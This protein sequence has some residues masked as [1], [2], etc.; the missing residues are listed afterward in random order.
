M[1]KASKKEPRVAIALKSS[2][3][4]SKGE[5]PVKVRVT[6]NRVQKFYPVRLDGK[7]VYLSSDTFN[8]IMETKDKDL[9]GD[10]R[11]LKDLF[12]SVESTAATACKTVTSRMVFTFER[13]QKEYLMHE[14]KS[15]ILHLFESYLKELLNDDRIG[16]YDSY[17]NAYHA[18]NKFRG[19]QTKPFARGKEL[20]PEDVTPELLK[21]FD[22]WLNEK[23]CNKT[24]V[25]IYMRA[26]RIIYNN[27]V[28]HNPSLA[29]FYPFARRQNSNRK[30][31]IRTGS[32][33]KGEALSV[34]DLQKFI[35]TTPEEGSPE[36][37]A[38][39]LW[40][41]MFYTSGMNAA[42]VFALQYKDIN[43]DAIRYVRR[44][45]RDTEEQEEVIEIPLSEALKKII[46]AIGN[47]DK[48]PAAYVF[49]VLD[50]SMDSQKMRAVTKQATKT[51][52]KWLSRLCA[53]NKLPEITTYWSRHTAATLLRNSGVPVEMI[54]ELL[55]HSDV[56]VTQEYLKRFS[57]EKKSNAIE[58]AL[59]A[60][61]V[62]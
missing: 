37:R 14:S 39:Q 33:S 2:H 58:A 34:E 54:S 56:R 43:W 27:A 51:I 57:V 6:F 7:P 29:E 45:T 19:G 12:K 46:V 16:S 28:E 55:G 22:K 21:K 48:S 38:K 52:N 13:F 31:K 30:Y 18:L 4:N 49:Q 35:A 23:G 41:F 8:H 9:R 61:K 15:G 36:W 47:P 53:D 1:V 11:K 32:G 3:K 24:T 5:H 62:S 42:D 60:V 50:K 10:N 17:K 25:G 26:V 44:K 40:L 20:L 59:M